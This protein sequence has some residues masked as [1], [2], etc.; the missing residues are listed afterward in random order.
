LR[1][2]NLN[3]AR[4]PVPPRPHKAPP[5]AGLYTARRLA[6]S[7]ASNQ[8]ARSRVIEAEK[9]KQQWPPRPHLNSQLPQVSQRSRLRRR[10]R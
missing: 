9:D 2:W 3:P 6:A 8:D 5:V 7:I 4:L 1:Y 10:P